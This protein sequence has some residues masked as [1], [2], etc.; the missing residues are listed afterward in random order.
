[1]HCGGD[2]AG[3]KQFIE[4]GIELNHDSPL[5][6]LQSVVCMFVLAPYNLVN[7]VSSRIIY[8]KR[9]CIAKMILCAIAIAGIVTLTNGGIMI[10]FGRFSWT[11]GKFPLVVMAIS[12]AVLILFYFL[13]TL[14]DFVTYSQL[15]ALSLVKT[16]DSSAGDGA[17]KFESTG[18]HDEIE[19]DEDTRE[20]SEIEGDVGTRKIVAAVDKEQVCEAEGKFEQSDEAEGKLEPG[21]SFLRRMVGESCFLSLGVKLSTEER[22][23]LQEELETAEEKSEYLSERALAVADAAAN[24]E[25]LANLEI[26]DINV[27]P[28]RFRA[29][30]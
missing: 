23:V 11:L 16:E 24:T 22:A 29:L 8:L 9:S 6:F 1:M 30:A 18:K 3:M 13:F 10:Y 27:I 15:D 28:S 14:V 5:Q 4:E 19:G 26:L 2:F 21:T 20:H 25:D 7:T 17:T 12:T